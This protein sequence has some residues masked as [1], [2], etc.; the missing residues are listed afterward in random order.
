MPLRSKFYPVKL[1][2][3]VKGGLTV[4]KE[5]FLMKVYPFRLNELALSHTFY[6]QDWRNRPYNISVCWNAGHILRGFV[7]ST[8][9][10][11]VWPE[12]IKSLRVNFNW[13]F[14]NCHLD[15]VLTEI[16]EISE[17]THRSGNLSI[18]KL[19]TTGLSPF[20]K[21]D[22]KFGENIKIRWIK[23]ECEKVFS[24]LK[25]VNQYGSRRV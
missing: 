18:D 4:L 13:N 5:L 24:V 9:K 14:L 25:W 3:I 10:C 21:T 1:A 23:T 16:I 17:S 11:I 6:R 12:I 2:R 15:T 20:H 19:V 8:K 7:T 22:S